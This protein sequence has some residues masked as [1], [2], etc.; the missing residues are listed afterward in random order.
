MNWGLCEAPPA[1]IASLSFLSRNRVFQRL[2]LFPHGHSH[3]NRQLEY[4]RLTPEVPA[5]PPSTR[6]PEQHS[7]SSN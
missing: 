5:V 6:E 2:E 7:S 1:A 3:L 4:R